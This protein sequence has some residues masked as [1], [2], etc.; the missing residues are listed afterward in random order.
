MENT[1][2][3]ILYSLLIVILVGLII[4]GVR[5][6]S[7]LFVSDK[8]STDTIYKV[9]DNVKEVD[10]L[11]NVIKV[12]QDSLNNKKVVR[13]KEIEV[14]YEKTIDSIRTLSSTQQVELLTRNLS[15]VDEN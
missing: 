12:K 14:R 5:N 11:I 10:S 9:I 1:I 15:Q 4:T 13:I 3:F 2:K 6:Y 8:P 7:S